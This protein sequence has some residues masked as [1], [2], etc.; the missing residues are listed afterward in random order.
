MDQDSFRHGRH[1]DDPPATDAAVSNGWL[2]SGDV[3]RADYQG[4]FSCRGRKKQIIV[5]DGSN[6]YPQEVE[7]ALLEHPSVADTGV[8]GIPD[9]VHGRERPRL[10]HAHPGQ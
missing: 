6:I 10:H 4:Y 2:D 7:G 1:W 5:H 3:L 9:L 8:T